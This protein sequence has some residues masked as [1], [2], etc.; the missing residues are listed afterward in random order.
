[1]RVVLIEDNPGDVYLIRYALESRGLQFD[2]TNY[3]DAPEAIDAIPEL[4]KAPPDVVLIDLSLPRGDGFS[5][6]S[7]IR[8]SSALATLPVAVLSS[9]VAPADEKTATG[10]NAKFFSKPSSL[11]EFVEVVISAVVGLTARARPSAAAHGGD[12]CHAMGHGF[13]GGLR[14]RG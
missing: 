8:K 3:P 12:G 7:E 5:V 4:E 1:M 11:E 2:L 14:Y 13:G 6:L 9:S 10:L